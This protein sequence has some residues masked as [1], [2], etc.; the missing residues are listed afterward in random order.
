MPLDSKLILWNIKNSVWISH[1]NSRNS[2]FAIGQIQNFF[3]GKIKLDGI[4]SLEQKIISNFL[5]QED[6]TR[7]R[8][9]CQNILRA[10]RNFEVHR[11]KVHIQI[12]SVEGSDPIGISETK[13][14]WGKFT[15]KYNVCPH[16]SY[17]PFKV[18][19]SML[20]RDLQ[21]DDC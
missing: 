13:E 1:E 17:L 6:W 11:K 14:F 2:Y 7:L 12:S 4:T 10:K 9:V 16:S 15:P 5:A 20:L 19:F 3:R 21:L 8:H 18:G